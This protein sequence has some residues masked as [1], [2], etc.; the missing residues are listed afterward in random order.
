MNTTTYNTQNPYKTKKGFLA[1]PFA[2]LY[3]ASDRKMSQDESIENL[4]HYACSLEE[5]I[6]GDFDLQT[7]VTEIK[8]Q[9]LSFV[10]TGL[11]AYKVKI[12]KL[13]RRVHKNFKT[14]CEKTLGISHWQINRKIEAARVV[15]ELAQAGFTVLPTCE[16]Q[17]R[18][19]TKLY[20]AELC[21]KWKTVVDSLEPHTITSNQINEVLGVETKTASLRLPKKL[22]EQIRRKALDMGLSIEQLLN[23]MFEDEQK[24]STVEREVLTKWEEDLKSFTNCEVEKT[25]E[26]EESVPIGTLSEKNKSCSLSSQAEQTLTKTSSKKISYEVKDSE[27]VDIEYVNLTISSSNQKTYVSQVKKSKNK[28]PLFEILDLDRKN[29]LK[30]KKIKRQA[31][32]NNQ[33]FNDTVSDTDKFDQDQS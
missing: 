15:I 13:Y 14:F 33:V 11:L 23:I 25:K 6:P 10:R 3:Q 28:K 22:Y 29:Q 26:S 20:G 1:D 12:S 27:S 16:A 17:A 24:T 19:F 18:P 4:I 5:C 32:Y 8:S 7:V 30:E 2:S 9:I 21:N 31:D